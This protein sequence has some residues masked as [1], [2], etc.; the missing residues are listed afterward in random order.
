MHKLFFQSILI[1]LLF[2][3]PLRAEKIF[4]PRIVTGES[5]ETI[6]RIMNLGS[7]QSAVPVHFYRRD[8]SP[9]GDLGL[10]FFLGEVSNTTTDGE[11]MITVGAHSITQYDVFDLNNQTEVGYFII[12]ADPEL[13]K[14]S[15]FLAY[16]PEGN[17][18]ESATARV[19]L[20]STRGGTLMSAPFDS[21]TAVS[22]INAED[23]EI[24]VTLQLITRGSSTVNQHEFVYNIEL[25]PHQSLAF[26]L[27]SLDFLGLDPID[28]FG[29]LHLW[30]E[31][32]KDR[33][34]ALSL[35]FPSTGIFTSLPVE[36]REDTPFEYVVATP[37][38]ATIA[39]GRPQPFNNLRES[40]AVFRT[41]IPP[42]T[43]QLTIT[44]TTPS[45][46]AYVLA[47]PRQLSPYAF[48]WPCQLFSTSTQTTSSC[49]IENPNPDYA[50]TVGRS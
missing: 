15:G 35:I 48:P 22:V 24:D 29:Q 44:L 32:G 47:S 39:R 41:R 33:F 38:I 50:R 16:Y 12:D 17:R 30:T 19:G 37:T 13:T 4:F 34:A 11:Q 36:I 45:L 18:T 26:F 6:F 9:W 20:L 46:S 8:G 21:D 40:P 2:W 42:K 7:D 14:L 5:W 28:F 31:G 1:V 3:V 27:R 43:R 10:R 25:G 23:H 49:L